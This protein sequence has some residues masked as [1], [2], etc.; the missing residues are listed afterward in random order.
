MDENRG[1]ENSVHLNIHGLRIECQAESSELLQDLVRPFRY[2]LVESGPSDYRVIVL[3]EAPDYAAFPELPA[4]F[5]TP[6]NVVYRD[7]SQKIIDYFGKGIVLEKEGTSS[8]W[9]QCESRNLI[10]EIFYLLVLSLLGQFCDRKGFLRIHALALAKNDTAV[11]LLLPQGG[12]KSTMASAMLNDPSIY[13]ISDDDPILDRQ[14]RIL[15]FPR[16]IGYLNEKALAGIPQEFIYSID[17]MEFGMKYYV[18]CDYWNNRI[19]KRPLDKIILFVGRRVLNGQPR[20]QKASTFLALST[21]MRD[22]VVGIGL[23]QGLEFLF[24]QSSWDA[25]GKIP[26][27]L[28]RTLRAIKLARKSD[29][30]V[31]TLSANPNRNCEALT[32]FLNQRFTKNP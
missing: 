22:A 15:P 5:V 13:Y 29:V 23:Y 12:G 28:K 31:F 8:Y 19:E 11:L 6:R 21:L 17:R 1:A 24:S 27:L 20:I 16:P 9:I 7:G 3:E 26:V 10:S 18:D 2:F 4:S 32:E 30:H 25:L 14:G